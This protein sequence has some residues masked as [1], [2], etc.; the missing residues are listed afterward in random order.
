[1]GV[2][3]FGVNVVAALVATI[4]SFAF[5]FFWHSPIGF[6]NQWMKL[7]KITPA[8]MAK[9]KKD[10]KKSNHMSWIYLAAVV[11]AFVV[12]FVLGWFIVATG[13][14]SAL[15]GAGIGALAWLGFIATTTLNGVLWEGRSMQ[16]WRFSNAYLLLN[17]MLMGAV[18]GAWG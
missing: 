13:M 14:S 10:A 4:V 3:V 7:M 11:N 16:I 1:M 9:A 18:L 5:G 2:L 8:Q 12:A 17:L 15:G 6:G